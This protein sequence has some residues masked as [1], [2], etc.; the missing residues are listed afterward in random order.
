MFPHPAARIILWCLA[1]FALQHL[2]PPALLLA[3]LLLAAQLTG[4]GAEV[5]LRLLRRT[6]WLLATMLLVYALSASGGAS[7]GVAALG[8][9]LAAGGMQ[10]ARLVMTLAVLALLLASTPAPDLLEGMS[11]LLQPLC[12]IGV[13]TDRFAVRVALTLHYCDAARPAADWRLWAEQLQAPAPRWHVPPPSGARMGRADVAAV[14]GGA[15][16]LVAALNF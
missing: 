5:F 14:A 1:V 16:L 9:G 8:A 3:A 10:I 2:S 13:N 7:D 6:R 15:A 4:G 11:C 12:R